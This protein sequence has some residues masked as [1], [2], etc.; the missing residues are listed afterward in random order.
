M[1]TTVPPAGFWKGLSELRHQVGVAQKLHRA[2]A[3]AI[4]L[5]HLVSDTFGALSF[6]FPGTSDL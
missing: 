4:P 5:H 2:H 3:Q 1:I 6:S